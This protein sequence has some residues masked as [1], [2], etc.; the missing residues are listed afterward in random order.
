MNVPTSAPLYL[1]EVYNSI[2]EEIRNTEGVSV[3]TENATTSV[4]SISLV[5][6]AETYVPI[7]P[8]I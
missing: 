2:V 3:I 1:T 5:T 6:L 7:D 4:P 8:V